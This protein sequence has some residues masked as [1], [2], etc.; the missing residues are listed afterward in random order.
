MNMAY[1]DQ[2]PRDHEMSDQELSALLRKWDVGGAPRGLEERVFLASG[3]AARGRRWW[4]LIP[5]AACGLAFA[6]GGAVWM[7]RPTPAVHLAPP[8]VIAGA[9]PAEVAAVSGDEPLPAAEQRAARPEPKHLG[10]SGPREQVR[11]DFLSGPPKAWAFDAKPA[12]EPL[13]QEVRAATP[14]PPGVYSIGNG[15][16]APSVAQKKEPEYSEEARTTRMAGTVLLQLVVGEDGTGRDITVL[17]PVGMGL[18]EKAVEAVSAW[19]FNPGMKNGAA[20]PVR[21]SI[22]VNFRLDKAGPWLLTRALFNPPAGAARPVLIEAPYPADGGSNLNEGIR[23]SFEVDENGVPINFRGET[24]AN[25]KLESEAVGILSGWR[26]RPGTL[27]GRAVTVP[28]TFDFVHAS[29]DAPAAASADSGDGP[30]RV[31][32]NAAAQNVIDQATPEYPAEAKAA[33]IHGKVSLG[34]RIGKDGH[35]ANAVVISGDPIL[36]QAALEAVRQWIYRPT[37]LNG[38]P[39]EVLTQ[40]DVNFTLSN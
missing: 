30:I 34:V 32:G 16:S 37:L 24:R 1:H 35:V 5:A 11:I 20:V 10:A 26:F 33:R 14:P 36:A 23:V 27:N 13:P 2:E 18:D 4:V 29:P 31:G 12:P 40:V 38:K 15:V 3:P 17:R 39:V 28:A 8:K 21:A 25:P 9:A 6:A 7:L 19:R 22:E